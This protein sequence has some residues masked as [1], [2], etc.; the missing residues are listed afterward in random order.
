MVLY[1]ILSTF[2]WFHRRAPQTASKDQRVSVS[3][4]GCLLERS[5][6]SGD[7]DSTVDRWIVRGAVAAMLYSLGLIG[8]SWSTLL[9]VN[10]WKLFGR[11]LS[12][13]WDFAFASICCVCKFVVGVC[14]QK[15][16]KHLS[17]TS[18]TIAGDWVLVLAWSK[19]FMALCNFVLALL[20]LGR[21]WGLLEVE[22]MLCHLMYTFLITVL[23]SLVFQSSA[24][25]SLLRIHDRAAAYVGDYRVF[26]HI[27]GCWW[28]GL[29]CGTFGVGA[30]IWLAGTMVVFDDLN[31]DARPFELSAGFDLMAAL[32]QIAAGVSMLYINRK[33]R[34]YFAPQ[35]TTDGADKVVEMQQNGG[36]HP[37]VIG[38]ASALP[39]AS[40]ALDRQ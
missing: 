7:V 22:H 6:S 39:G 21:S 27:V 37:D 13:L 30:G 28:T 36:V 26:S 31:D 38:T 33:V 11:P 10:N 29:V 3:A 25:F 35:D 4:Y 24:A 12:W 9:H 5:D 20:F 23:L 14:A 18:R 19:Y 1:G 32:S 2:G 16:H 15:V 40:G 34:H 17:Q 8:L